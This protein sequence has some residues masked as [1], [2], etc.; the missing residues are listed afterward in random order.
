MHRTASRFRRCCAVRAPEDLIA[1]KI[2]SSDHLGI[3]GG[4]QGG[5]L[6]GGTFVQRPELFK[7][8]VCLVPLLDMKRY[9]KLLAGNSCM[10]KRGLVTISRRPARPAVWQALQR[11][12]RTGRRAVRLAP[13]TGQRC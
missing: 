11:Q 6:V 3:M 4:S 12:R 13:Q 1:R 2:T 10:A 7:A 9:N 8:V 5:L